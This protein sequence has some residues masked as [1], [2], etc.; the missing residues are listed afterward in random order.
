V[1]EYSKQILIDSGS[2]PDV[3]N[4]DLH[5]SQFKP[6]LDLISGQNIDKTL[7]LKRVF[8]KCSNEPSNIS[9]SD[10]LLEDVSVVE[11]IME[12]T[13]SNTALDFKLN[14]IMS[15]QAYQFDLNL[16]LTDFNKITFLCNEGKSNL[17]VSIQGVSGYRD[18]ITILAEFYNAPGYHTLLKTL[19]AAHLNEVIT[20]LVVEHKMASII[21][22]SLFVKVVYY[23]VVNNK[24]S[25]ITLLSDVQR[26]LY[27][28]YTPVQNRVISYAWHSRSYMAGPI[29]T[30]G[31]FT[32][33]RIVA[34]GTSNLFKGNPINN[35]KDFIISSINLFKDFNVSQ[36]DDYIR[37]VEEAPKNKVDKEAP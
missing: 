23:Q 29:H 27:K 32:I 12:N 15:S 6:T 14:Q 20:F 17:V 33:G 5:Y 25:F 24:G 26:T 7:D 10:V 30:L 9:V 22:I 2:F 3:K 19:Y 37:V 18:V 35:L 21:G 11:K 36:G 28:K 1:K 4:L 13:L 8:Y 31:S 34:L 16:I